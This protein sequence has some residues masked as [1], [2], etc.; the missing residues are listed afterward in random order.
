MVSVSMWAVLIDEGVIA[1]YSTFE[2]ADES[3][4]DPAALVSEN[5]EQCQSEG[6][7]LPKQGFS[8]VLA[9]AQHRR[10]R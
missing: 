8:G 3:G 9:P 5:Y 1:D 4:F 2:Q 10:A 6:A 7:R